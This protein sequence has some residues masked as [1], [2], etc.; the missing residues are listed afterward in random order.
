M[1]LAIFCQAVQRVDTKSSWPVQTGSAEIC[2]GHEIMQFFAVF[3]SASTALLPWVRLAAEKGHMASRCLSLVRWAPRLFS[4]LWEHGPCCRSVGL[5]NEDFINAMGSIAEDA[6][7]AG[8]AEPMALCGFLHT[9]LPPKPVTAPGVVASL[10]R[11]AEELVAT[12]NVHR[13]VLATDV[14]VGVIYG[15]TCCRSTLT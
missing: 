7:L 8:R 9:A 2:R 13:G 1:H 5:S 11:L 10:T 12:L 15:L 3:S 14:A 4:I 6:S